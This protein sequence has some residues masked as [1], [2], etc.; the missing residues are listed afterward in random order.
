M[1]ETI[2]FTLDGAEV[3]ASEGETIW[4]VAKREGKVIP[5]LCHKDQTGYVP[6]GNCRACVVE[7]EGERVLAAS[8]CRNPSNGMVV[9]TESERALKSRNM[10]MELLLADQPDQ[11]VA[12]DASAHL[13]DMADANGVHE[14]RFPK[15]E[16]ARIPLLDDSHVAMRV[17]LDACIQCGLCVR[18]C[19]D[20]QV[21]D[22]IGMAGRGHDAFPVFDMADPMGLSTCVACGECVQ[23]CPT[24]ALMPATV[25]DE[26]QIGDSK[27][28]DTRSY[29]CLPVLRRR[30]PGLAEGQGRQGQVCRRHQRPRQRGPAVRQGPLRLRLY[31]PP[32]PADQAADP[33]RGCAGKGAERRSRK[34]AGALPRSHRGTRRWT[35]RRTA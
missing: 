14:S 24:G 32:A 18:A 13:W 16:K 22:V 20:V 31:P 15:L 25:L 5:H 33:A 9:K 8:C 6:D 3:T 11:T 2:K 35:P 4:E 10:V 30:L 26:D 19:R 1:T 21:N 23:A 12:H 28:F 17:N 34:L 29:F 7:V 27:D